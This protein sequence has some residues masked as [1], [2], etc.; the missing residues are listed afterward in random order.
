M[1][2]SLSNK[3][4]KV[5]SSIIAIGFSPT[6]N[7]MTITGSGFCVSGDGKIL[8]VAH[9][10]NQTPPQFQSKLMGMVMVKQEPN[11]LEHYTWLPLSF[12]KKEDKNDVSLF[13]IEGSDK[14]LLK[15][16]E[17]G[18]SDEIEIGQDTYFLGFPY[19]A[20]L[21]NEGFGITLVVN[22]AI[23]SNIKQDGID[24]IHPRNWFVID[25]ISNP[26]N[27][28]CPLIDVETNKVIGVMSIA[29]RTKS[30][31]AKYSDLDIRE[32][33]HIAGAKP[34]NLAKNIL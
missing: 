5:R 11:G 32:P 8:T 17:L 30:Q 23:I 10:Y 7:Q 12:I 33:M 22:R 9:V 20:Q 6:P 3:I 34:I 21:M 19:A 24:L 2:S 13:Q 15:P 29:F 27:S 31:V 28:G 1:H 18:N 4:E 25:A 26:G 14:T 16:L